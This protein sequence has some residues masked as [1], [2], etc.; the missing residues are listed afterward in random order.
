VF[1]S[2][3]VFTLPVGVLVDRWS[4]KKSI[5]VM[6]IFWSLATLACAFTRNFQQL[7]TART[8]IGIGEAGYVP[9]GGA[10]VSAMY[11]AEKRSRMLGIWQSAIPLGS[12]MGVLL[13]GVIATQFGWRNALGIVAIPG[14]LLAILFFWVRD[15]KT[16][17]LTRRIDTTAA[18]K[19]R[20]SRW[21]MVRELFRSPSL[22]MAN[23]A[24]AGCAFATTALTSWLPTYFQRFEN[25]PIDRAG[26][27]SSVVMLLA[28]IGAPLGGFL[29]DQW[30]K[31]KATARMLLP[32]ISTAVACVLL[33]FSFFGL[34]GTSQY[35][36]L[37][38][39]GVTV[40]MFAPGAVAVTQDVVH[41][42][43]RATSIGVCIVIQ[44]L[45]GS[46]LGPL[47]VGAASDAYGLDKAMLM[48]PGFLALAALLFFI[49]SFF[50]VRDAARA[51]KVE[52]VFETK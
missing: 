41:P 20:M 2:I 6:A 4:R 9:G 48:L 13:G 10:M 46:A 29:T 28:I 21:D 11:P 38:L 31:K 18:A 25:M 22:V 27:M 17:E 45:L 34:H 44:H 36:M 51:E 3:L 1:W 35:I 39:V 15:Y 16:P 30:F 40:I 12:A 47:V 26:T 43:L 5:G 14:M 23:L 24:F 19:V 7:F 37:L 33:F 52:L 50:Y 49:G 32:A 8:A 42:G